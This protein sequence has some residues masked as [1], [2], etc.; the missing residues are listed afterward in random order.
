M[1]EEPRETSW[2]TGCVGFAGVALVFCAIVF[3]AI[4]IEQRGFDPTDLCD[5]GRTSGCITKGTGVIES[6]EARLEDVRVSY[7]DGTKAVDVLIDGQEEPTPGTHV[8]L[9]WWD[10]D[11]VALV[12]RDSGR[13]YQ[14]GDWPDPW[15]EWLAVWGALAV[16][17][18]V[19]LAAVFGTAAGVKRLLRRR[20]AAVSKGKS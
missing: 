17:A 7:D 4:A 1:A 10:G 15:W 14:T 12:E 13:R 18:G 6:N 11:V 16:M 8:I 2:R 5:N 9:Q 3:V 20:Q 19:V